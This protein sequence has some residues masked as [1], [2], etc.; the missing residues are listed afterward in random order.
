[1]IRLAH[2]RHEMDSGTPPDHHPEIG[3]WAT[4]FFQLVGVN[5]CKHVIRLS[6]LSG[7]R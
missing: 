6:D 4:P 3:K 5:Q 2:L 7:H 1:M